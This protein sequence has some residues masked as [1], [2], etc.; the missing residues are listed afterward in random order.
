MRIATPHLRSLNSPLTLVASC[1]ST[2]TM[3]YLVFWFYQYE[4]CQYD[5][6]SP[7]RIPAWDSIYWKPDI[8]SHQRAKD[9]DRLWVRGWVLR[10]AFLIEAVV[11]CLFWTPQWICPTIWQGHKWLTI[12]TTTFRKFWKYI[13]NIGFLTDHFNKYEI[14]PAQKTWERWGR[15]YSEFFFSLKIYW[16]DVMIYLRRRHHAFY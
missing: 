4:I 7:K 10:V 12:L 15:L 2:E 6:I 11:T 14:I 13:R 9:S 1:V 16:K 5:K 8:E 3:G